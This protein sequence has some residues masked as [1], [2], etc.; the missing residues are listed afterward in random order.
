MTTS[1]SAI[2]SN[3]V[4]VV[5]PTFNSSHYLQMAIQSVLNQ[6]YQD[7]EI[8]VVD[9]GSTDDTQKVAS[10]FGRKV[11]YFYQTNQGSPIARNVGLKL[12]K[13]KYL[14]LLDSDDLFLPDRLERGVKVLDQMP[15]IDL[16]HGE[17]KVIDSQGTVISEDTAYFQKFYAKERKQGSSYLHVLNG[18]AMFPSSI[19]FRRECLD[20]IGFFNPSFPPREDYDWYLRFALHHQIYLLEEPAVV[21]YRRHRTNQCLKFDLKATSHIYV[22]ILQ[23]QLSLISKYFSGFQYQRIR[24]SILAKLAEYY[25]TANLKKEVR[26]SLF[27][28]IRLNPSVAFDPC[29][30][31]RLILSL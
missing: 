9:D 27:E 4:S 8:I 19:L 29:S 10:S 18:N 17:V 14:A 20:Q 28:A 13:G 25:W 1:R 21:L 16:V 31:K 30:L 12:A 24:G 15:H 2:I 3:G 26:T 5:I 11:S 7:F 23:Q 6:T 22:A